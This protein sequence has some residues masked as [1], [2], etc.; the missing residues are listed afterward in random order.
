M[1]S[2]RESPFFSFHSVSQTHIED[3]FAPFDEIDAWLAANKPHAM[4]WFESG[5]DVRFDATFMSAV[6]ECIAEDGDLDRLLADHEYRQSQMD[7]MDFP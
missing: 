5:Q 7:N 6:A 2:I 4:L 1:T 3:V